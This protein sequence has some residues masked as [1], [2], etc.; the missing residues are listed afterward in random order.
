MRLTI[1]LPLLLAPLAATALRFFDG[2]TTQRPL[3]AASIAVPGANPL[4]HCHET[5]D[6]LLKIERLD[7]DPN[8]PH[9]YACHFPP[10]HIPL[11]RCFHAPHETHANS[12]Y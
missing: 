8:P 4:V 10:A 12:R 11:S 9:A 1:I 6:D 3:G 7:L 2:D 5:D